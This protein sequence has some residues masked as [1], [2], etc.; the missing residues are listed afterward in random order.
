MSV[1]GG[2][3]IV[4]GARGDS[5]RDVD[6]VMD[7]VLAPLMLLLG[8]KAWADAT[9]RAVAARVNLTILICYCFG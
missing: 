8:A 6:D 2:P 1:I 9:R 3:Q 5:L 4:R 7:A